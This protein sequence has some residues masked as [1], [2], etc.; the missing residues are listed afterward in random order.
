VGTVAK[1]REPVKDRQG[2]GLASFGCSPE[3]F[4]LLQQRDRAERELRNLMT[5]LEACA[6]QW[7]DTFLQEVEPPQ[8]DTQAPTPRKARWWHLWRRG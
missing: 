6:V 2:E 3:L 8:P 5:R 7:I 1:M 4:H